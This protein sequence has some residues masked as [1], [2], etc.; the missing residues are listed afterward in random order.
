MLPTLLPALATLAITALVILCSNAYVGTKKIAFQAFFFVSGFVGAFTYLIVHQ[1]DLDLTR[2][3]RAFANLNDDIRLALSI[4]VVSAAYFGGAMYL[5]GPSGEGTADAA[6][7]SAMPASIDRDV[8]FFVPGN[9]PQDDTE[10][11]TM[12]FEK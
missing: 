9:L 11:F 12:M 1:D 7:S 4:L 8:D 3:Y 6:A 10:F 5:G 2:F